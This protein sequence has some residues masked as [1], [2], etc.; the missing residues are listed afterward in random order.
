MHVILEPKYHRSC[1]V[2]GEMIKEIAAKSCR[3]QQQEFKS[4]NKTCE[5]S[6]EQVN[7]IAVKKNQPNHTKGV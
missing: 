7:V 3:E 6:T 2:A 4:L 1:R 5:N